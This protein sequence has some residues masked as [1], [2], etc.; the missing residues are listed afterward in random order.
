MYF[1]NTRCFCRR[2]HDTTNNNAQSIQ[3]AKDSNLPAVQTAPSK[4][5]NVNNEIFAL[6]K[7]AYE[8]NLE[9]VKALIAKGADVN[10]KGPKDANFTP[11]FFA[12]SKGH[13]DIRG[14]FDTSGFKK[15]NE[16]KDITKKV[17]YPRLYTNIASLLL[18]NGAD[19]NA[20]ASDGGPRCI[21]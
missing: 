5:T 18:A 15:F 16:V 20:K 9:E 1:F 10:A 2:K 3:A 19:I 11:L 13:E 7:A 14:L 4:D 17:D 12:V 6:H 8:G 21:W